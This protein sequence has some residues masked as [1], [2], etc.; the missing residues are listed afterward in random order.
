MNKIINQYKLIMTYIGII[1]LVGFIGSV[2]IQ[3]TA[4]TFLPTAPNWTEEAA[5]FLFIYMVAFGGNAAVI[6]DESRWCRNVDRDVS[7]EC[8]ER[9]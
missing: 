2:L 8:S 6:T 9:N 5:R 4:R 7:K 1:G 3:V